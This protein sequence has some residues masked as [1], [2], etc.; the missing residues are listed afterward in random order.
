M[1][2]HYNSIKSWVERLWRFPPS[3]RML[4]SFKQRESAD[5]EVW[6]DVVDSPAF[7]AMVPDPK[8]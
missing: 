2:L 6:R 8:M 7:K 1:K 4:C 5:D 3:A